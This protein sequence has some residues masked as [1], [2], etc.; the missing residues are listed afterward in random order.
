MESKEYS[1]AY[2]TGNR[3]LSHGPCELIFA[4]LGPGAATTDAVL[5]DGENT[6]GDVIVTLQ[7]AVVTGMPFNP[8]VPIYCRKGLYF[9]QGSSTSTTAFVQWRE[10]GHKAG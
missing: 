3:L 6:S 1:W 7:A 8:P 4:H 2:L 9:A 10:L 5:Y